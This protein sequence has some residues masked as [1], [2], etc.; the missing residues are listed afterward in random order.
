MNRTNLTVKIFSILTSLLITIN[1]FS[2]PGGKDTY[3]EVRTEC[4]VWNGFACV[5][6][7][8]LGQG[9][10]QC[11]P[12]V[13]GG[14]LDYDLVASIAEANYSQNIYSTQFQIIGNPSIY[15]LTDIALKEDGYYEFKL[16]SLENSNTTNN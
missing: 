8:C 11:V 14:E 12:Q 3:R 5:V 4:V 6:T 2:S 10:L 15:Y 16:T 1:S 13:S 7:T 9:L